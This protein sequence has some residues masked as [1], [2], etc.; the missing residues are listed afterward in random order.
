MINNKKTWI[1]I[2]EEYE[3]GIKNNPES[4]WICSFSNTFKAI[5]E[6]YYEEIRDLANNFLLSEKVSEDWFVG[7]IV[8][9]RHLDLGIKDKQRIRLEFID[10]MI[11]KL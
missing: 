7:D 10:Y 4:C 9:F 1:Q 2:K 3:I 11:N 5:W 6:D 8:L